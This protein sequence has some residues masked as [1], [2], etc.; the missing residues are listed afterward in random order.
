MKILQPFLGVLISHFCENKVSSKFIHEAVKLS[1]LKE[2]DFVHLGYP[3][4][5]HLSG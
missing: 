4:L 3:L 1:Q 2:A 5:E